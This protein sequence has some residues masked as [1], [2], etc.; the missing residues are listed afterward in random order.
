M[1]IP[2]EL[3]N[4]LLYLFEDTAISELSASE[5]ALALC[6]PFSHSIVGQTVP[7]PQLHS[8]NYILYIYQ[9][10]VRL[11]STCSRQPRQSAAAGERR[12]QRRHVF[13]VIGMIAG[14]LALS[15]FFWLFFATAYTNPAKKP[16]ET[17]DTD[18][19][20]IGSPKKIMPDAA[21]GSLFNAPTM[22]DKQTWFQ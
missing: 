3:T 11:R 21:T 13:R 10:N 5:A 15:A 8:N 16:I 17:A 7:H 22:L 2:Q 12:P 4:S 20:V 18:P 14:W 9:L 6:G 19:N 1:G